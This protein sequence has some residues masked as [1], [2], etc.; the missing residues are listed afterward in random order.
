V[1]YEREAADEA[2]PGSVNIPLDH[3]RQRL[4]DLPSGRP[5]VVYCQSGQ[6][7]SMAASLL[8]Q[9]GHTQVLDLVGGVAAWKVAVTKRGPVH[10]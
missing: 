4:A 8:E 7:S 6:R 3:L 9:A 10:A 2:I 5:L 1:R